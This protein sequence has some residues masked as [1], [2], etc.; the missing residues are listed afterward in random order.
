[1]HMICISPTYY[2]NKITTVYDNTVCTGNLLWCFFVNGNIFFSQ[3]ILN[4][5]R[6]HA[7]V[8]FCSVIWQQLIC[9]FITVMQNNRTDKFYIKRRN[10]LLN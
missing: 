1:M 4:K 6:I 10:E 9:L 3:H 8:L 5:T 2:K 7:H